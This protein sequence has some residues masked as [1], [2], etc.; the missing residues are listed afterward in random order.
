MFYRFNYASQNDYNVNDSLN[1][2]GDHATSTVTNENETVGNAISEI[3]GN[4][5]GDTANIGNE[6]ASTRSSGGG[7]NADTVRFLTSAIL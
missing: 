6:N 4:C 2:P 7:P 5:A 3:N 1:G